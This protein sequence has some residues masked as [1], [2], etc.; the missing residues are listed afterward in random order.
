MA[1]SKG[2]DALTLNSRGNARGAVGDWEGAKADFESAAQDS[3]LF[4]IARA[5]YALAAFETGDADAAIRAARGLLRRDP[6]F[7]DARA[8]LTAFLWAEGKESGEI[9]LRTHFVVR[10]LNPSAAGRG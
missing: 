8:F 7:W 2:R 10:R 3:L 9:Y 6:E 4:A 5:N 1:L